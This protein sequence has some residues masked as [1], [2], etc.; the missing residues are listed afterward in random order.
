VTELAAEIGR[1][2][3]LG[4]GDV[5]REH[6]NDAGAAPVRR[7]HD[8]VGLVVAGAEDGA[9]HLHDEFARRVVVVEQDHLV[10]TRPLG[11]RLY[12]GLASGVGIAHRA[13][14]C[15]L[16]DM[17][18]STAP[19]VARTGRGVQRPEIQRRDA[20][21]RSTGVGPERHHAQQ[22]VDDLEAHRRRILNLDR[23]GIDAIAHRRA[24][25]RIGRL[26]VF[27]GRFPGGAAGL[28]GI[29]DPAALGVAMQARTE[30]AV[31]R[32]VASVTA[33]QAARNSASRPGFTRQR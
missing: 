13:R 23:F 32:Q 19:S 4:L 16:K 20:L 14:R 30:T 1:F 10:E 2:L 33:T 11:L 17:A 27:P 21:L 29:G 26:A 5:A 8:A 15:F 18:R 9:Q 31:V 25:G 7:H 12:P 22:V 28:L 3:R 24:R 6:R